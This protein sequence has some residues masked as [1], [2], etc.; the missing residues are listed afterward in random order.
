MGSPK[1]QE[2]KYTLPSRKEIEKAGLGPKQFRS[3]IP[4]SAFQRM[5]EYGQYLTDRLN[6]AREARFQMVG[7]PAEIGA[8]VAGRDAA[9]QAAYASALPA[10]DQ[11]SPGSFLTDAPG[12]DASDPYAQIREQTQNLYAQALADAAAK[13]A[14]A[15]VEPDPIPYSPVSEYFAS[16]KYET[17]RVTE[18]RVKPWR[19]A[20]DERR[21]ERNR[22]KR[23]RRNRERGTTFVDMPSQGPFG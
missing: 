18:S 2:V 15:A 3:V 5:G 10:G 22:R 4:P 6:Q 13:Q 23:R 21:G 16:G 9:T 19:S 12:G 17:P 20:R 8:R 1:P 11:Y 7:T 14:E